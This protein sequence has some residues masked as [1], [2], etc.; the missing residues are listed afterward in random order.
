[1]KEH[2]KKQIINM[3]LT[4]LIT[5]IVSLIIIV[6]WSS[7]N[8][9]SSPCY[10]CHQNFKTKHGSD[11]CYIHSPVAED[12]CESCHQEHGMAR[13]LV[14]KGPIQQLCGKCHDVKKE[15]L[16]KMH[17]GYYIPPGSCI[18]CHNPHF[19]K[20]KKLIHTYMH[21]SFKQG[22]CYECHEKR[23]DTTKLILPEKRIC[24]KCHII[25]LESSLKI[26]YHKPF[27]QGDCTACHDPHT[28]ENNLNLKSETAQICKEK[29]HKDISKRHNSTVK[30]DRQ[31]CVSCHAYHLSFNNKLLK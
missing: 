28:S 17:A 29:C 20:N 13:R 1:M 23:A 7:K 26:N 19:S 22:N 31:S 27:I 21:P 12:E 16:A 2:I 3:N 18:N 30:I 4:K 25:K 15:E 9:A 8:F 24:S 10:R 14:L 11:S 5:I 6:L